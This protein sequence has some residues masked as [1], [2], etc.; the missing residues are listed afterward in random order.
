MYKQ[1]CTVYC[2]DLT[3]ASHSIASR[4]PASM[5]LQAQS[6]QRASRSEHTAAKKRESMSPFPRRRRAPFIPSS[7]YREEVVVGS[8]NKTVAAIANWR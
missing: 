5:G 6:V 4:I 2:L 8:V 3:I 7:I 1:L